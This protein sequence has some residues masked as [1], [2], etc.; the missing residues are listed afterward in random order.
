M[1]KISKIILPLFGL[2]IFSCAYFNTF[3]NAREYFNKAEES[4]KN[5]K[6]KLSI[7]D[8]NQYQKVIEKSQIVID[9]YPESK[10]RK[11]AFYLIGKSH[12]HR[13]EYTQAEFAFKKLKAEY[14]LTVEHET[15]FWL[16]LIK[17]KKGKPQPA[18]NDLELIIAESDNNELKAQALL[19]S[20]DIYLELES[21][22][23][24]LNYLDKAAALTK[25]T[26]EKGEIYFRISNSAFESGDL[27]RA[28][29][30]Y[31]LVIK[32]SKNPKYN[33]EAH[34]KKVQ[35]YRISGEN[36]RVF[37]SIKSLLLDIKYKSIYGDLEMELVHL[38][39]N[40][41]RTPEA[42]NRLES[43][44]NEYPKTTASAEAY[45]LLGEI[46]LYRDWNLD[47]ALKYFESSPHES[48]KSSFSAS[49]MVKK[50]EIKSFQKSR[51]S[52]KK[53]DSEKTTAADSL[54]KFMGTGPLNSIANDLYN[55]AE[56]NALH[57]NRPLKAIEDLNRILEEFPESD[58]IPK[59]LYTRIYLE[60]NFG[61]A[62]D[63]LFYR[64]KLINDYPM[65]E[66]AQAILKNAE[67]DSGSSEINNLLLAAEKEWSLNLPE[68]LLKYKLIL[69]L[70]SLSS[71]GVKA[72]YFLAYSYDQIYQIGD[73]AKKYYDWIV[74]HYPE[75]E[76]GLKAKER[77]SVLIPMLKDNK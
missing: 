77:L 2:L 58:L 30:A 74:K 25:D 32:Y 66:Y 64:E 1:M 29:K 28:L 13:G 41:G 76:Q 56:L 34:L 60:Q 6:N 40:Q 68:T 37:E 39:L 47:K 63:D 48:K 20:G 27:N 49:A 62:E 9:E 19:F 46:A 4:R 72:A 45:F 5:K 35:I 52:I 3:Y 22:S 67:I 10:L 43:I 15:N 57:F 53:Y 50:K 51:K 14:G 61:S 7:T 70:D 36:E 24:A 26:Y 17:W 11:P 44:V 21:D 65:S 69:E 18:L 33:Q 54:E 31:D 55:L 59:V 8:L 23:I 42:E 75:T 71:V 38:Y 16:A 73:S 12:Y